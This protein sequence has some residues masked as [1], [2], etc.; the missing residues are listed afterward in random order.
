MTT[1]DTNPVD[2]KFTI[3]L[4]HQYFYTEEE[5]QNADAELSDKIGKAALIEGSIDIIYTNAPEN[6]IIDELAPWIQNLCFLV[7]Q[8][9]GFS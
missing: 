4:D 7:L 6:R 2:V 8:S 9:F 5:I 1:T 3:T